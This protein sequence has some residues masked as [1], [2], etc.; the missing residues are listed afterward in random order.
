MSTFKISVNWKNTFTLEGY[1]R[2][3]VVH[4]SGN[5]SLQ[6][7]SAPDF[8]GNTNM[9][10]PEE[11]LA[12]ALASCHML[13]FLAICSKSRLLVESYDDQAVAVLEKNED[14]KMAVTKITLHPKI[15][16]TGDQI[17]DAEKIK[18]LHDKAHHNCFI[19]NSIKCHVEVKE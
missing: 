10:N 1:N 6:N 7:S 17:P 14:G 9:A 5:Q 16:F 3:H 18:S 4:Y 11:L 2:D 12:S 19:A 8:S 15:K 13:T